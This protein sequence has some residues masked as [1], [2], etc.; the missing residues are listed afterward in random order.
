MGFLDDLKRQADAAR[1]QQTTDVK[2]LARNAQLADIACKTANDYFGVLA[3]QLNV[4]QPRSKVPYRL[5]RRTVFN[6]LQ[7]VGFRADARRKRLRD[8]EVFDH[9]VLRWTLASGAALTLTKNFLP[10][11]EQLEA[12][13]RQGGVRFEAEAV[14]HPESAKLQ[15]MRYAFVGDLGASVVVTPDHERGRVRFELANLDGFETV[16]VEFPAFEIGSARLD[17]LA[18]WVLGE[19]N[20]FLTNGQALRRVEA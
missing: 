4:L 20:T 14:R 16:T 10:D 1:A 5:D 3:Q 18:R 7:L 17:E 13:L 19:P 8:E 9:A 2:A 11:I 6:E 12:R 15:E